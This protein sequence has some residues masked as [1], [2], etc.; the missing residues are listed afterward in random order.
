MRL[1]QKSNPIKTPDRSIRSERKSEPKKFF[2]DWDDYQIP[3]ID[4][5][6]VDNEQVSKS[7]KT[8]C[9]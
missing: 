5:C 7:F 2:V 3:E 6:A 8:S 9:Y 1:N 4:Y